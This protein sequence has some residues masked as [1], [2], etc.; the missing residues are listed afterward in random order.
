MASMASSVL[1]SGLWETMLP[2]RMA[3]RVDKALVYV[4]IREEAE[5]E[6]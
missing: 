6:E 2:S 4:A 5:K 3:L 1:S